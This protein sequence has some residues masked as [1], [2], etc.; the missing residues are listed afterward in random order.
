MSKNILITRGG[1]DGHQPLQTSERFATFLKN[2]GANV[3]ISDSLNCYQDNT[4]MSSLDLIVQSW[5]CGNLT[6]EQWKGLD[7]TVKAGCGFAGWHGGVID[8]FRGNIDYQWMVGAQ[9]LGHPGNIKWHE[10]VIN[11]WDDPI[12][13]GI[14]HFKIKSEQYYMLIDPSNQVLA[15]TTFDGEHD[16]LLRGVVMPVVWKR[17]WG[18]GRVFASAIGHV[19]TDFN[20]D[21]AR[22]I[23]ER[24]IIWAMRGPLSIGV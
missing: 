20:V 23:M 1:W 8:A 7:S 16:P 24:G 17:R 22:I 6:N 9:F 4:L 10:V 2:Q 21:E 19:D 12:T 3:T 5:T 14:S 13:A 11:D 15:T 18:A